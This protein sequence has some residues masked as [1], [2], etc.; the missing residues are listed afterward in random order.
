M[1]KSTI[2]QNIIVP[3]IFY[4]FIIKCEINSEKLP[5][6][7]V[8]SHVQSHEINQSSHSEIYAHFIYSR[9]ANTLI[10]SRSK[11]AGGVGSNRQT[12]AQLPSCLGVISAIG[13]P[14]NIAANDRLTRSWKKKV[15]NRAPGTI[16]YTR[17]RQD[18]CHRRAAPSRPPQQDM[19]VAWRQH[20]LSCTIIIAVCAGTRQKM[21][22]SIC[23]SCCCWCFAPINA[24]SFSPPPARIHA[25]LLILRWE[26]RL[27]YYSKG[28]TV[29]SFLFLILIFMI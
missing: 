8:T 29:A 15:K 7:R 16:D 20:Q 14:K 21:Y 17:V 13:S 2:P 9:A 1:Q 12:A 5:L 24:M 25:F 23:Y 6:H 28:E 3:I 22:A 18:N 4:N 19:L 11:S 27:I 10:F 26:Y